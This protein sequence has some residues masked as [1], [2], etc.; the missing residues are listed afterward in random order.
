MHILSYRKIIIRASKKNIHLVKMQKKITKIM[1]FWYGTISG[2]KMAWLTGLFK[3]ITTFKSEI[4][5]GKVDIVIETACV[6]F[7]L[8][9][10]YRTC[11]Y[12]Y[13]D[14]FCFLYC[15]KNN[16]NMVHIHVCTVM[17]KIAL[18]VFYWLK[19]IELSY[20]YP[21]PHSTH[22]RRLEVLKRTLSFFIF[23]G[24]CM[25]VATETI[26]LKSFPK[27]WFCFRCYIVHFI[28]II[29]RFSNFFNYLSL[30]V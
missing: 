18:H 10:T 23:R 20:I 17:N 5:V 2:L 28:K 11:I 9:F 14:L 4:R 6:L 30:V 13:N 3:E 15:V 25:L 7:N 1:Y 29:R 22:V 27:L 19:H 26:G 8:S 24:T 21:I 12:R 16:S